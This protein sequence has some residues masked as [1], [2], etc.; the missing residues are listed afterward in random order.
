MEKGLPQNVDLVE[1]CEIEET[2]AMTETL[3][4]AAFSIG[5]IGTICWAL[6]YKWRGYPV[7]GWFW[8][9]S[10]LLWIWFAL[11]SKHNGLAARDILGVALYCAG[12]YKS[13]QPRPKLMVYTPIQ[14][15][16]TAPK[17]DC[18]F[19]GGTGVHQLDGPGSTICACTERHARP[20][21]NWL[22][23]H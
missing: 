10:A 6:G 21:S 8:L 15:T 11:L 4:W 19:C 9:L 14:Q 2:I 22:R 3:E 13:F 1:H 16:S 7:E 18:G 5:T 23:G 20:I 12:I 17:K